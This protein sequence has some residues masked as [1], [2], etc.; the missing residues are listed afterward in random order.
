MTST[1]VP[2]K[3]NP[4]DPS[5]VQQMIGYCE[6]MHKEGLMLEAKVLELS[7]ERQLEPVLSRLS[8]QIGVQNLTEIVKPFAGNTRELINW[9]KS[10]EKFARIIVGSPALSDQEV[11]Q[12]AYRTSRQTMS[13]F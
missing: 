9:H 12:V 2:R 6:Q 8:S 10:C 13:D 5:K 7:K 1:F 4:S 11:I 3:F